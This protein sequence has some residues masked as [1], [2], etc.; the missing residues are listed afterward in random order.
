MTAME[1]GERRRHP[2]IPVELQAA[3]G[4]RRGSIADLSLGGARLVTFDPMPV[5]TG[6]ELELFVSGMVMHLRAQAI[7]RHEI[8]PE[9][10]DI[11]LEFYDLDA[12]QRTLLEA[13]LDSKAA[14]MEI[15]KLR[16]LYR[17][18][19][20]DSVLTLKLAGYFRDADGHR[21][22]QCVAEELEATRGDLTIL[23]EALDHRCC[24]PSCQG[25]IVE[26]FGLFNQRGVVAGAL[27]CQLEGLS[28]VQLCRAVRD[29][30][31][32]DTFMVFDSD[33]EALLFL[34]EF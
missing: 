32:G 15:A 22:R 24:A 20:E 13:C 8:E 23:V 1:A 31:L 16:E 6:L 34:R 7:R 2:R 29:A 3:V 28:R 4:D 33:R 17:V 11:G 27:V 5:G 14:D 30:S 10:F 25:I 9:L 12:T 18:E 26:C 19:I 21:L